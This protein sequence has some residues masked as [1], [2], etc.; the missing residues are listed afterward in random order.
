M[1]RRKRTPAVRPAEQTSRAAVDQRTVEFDEYAP[2]Y[3]DLLRHPVRDLFAND[4]GYF[5][6]RKWILIHDFFSKRGANTAD[7]TWLDVGCGQGELLALGAK[8]FNRAVGCDPSKKMITTCTE[9]DV[10]EQSSPSELPFP[11]ESFDF[12]T[13]VCVYHHVELKDRSS[14]TN[15]IHRVLKRGGIFCLIEH[16]PY[17]PVTQLIV[18]KC[19]VDARARLLTASAAARLL[20]SAGL[21]IIETAYFLYF[22]EF[23]FGHTGWIENFLRKLPVG[24]QFV[25]F[26]RKAAA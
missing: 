14:L 15:S 23:I 26:G 6:R 18:K 16:N 3:S 12:V 25:I 11:G 2:A 7:L 13:A 22:P 24:G 1:I 21:G 10:F 5:H 19:P 9:A 17:N 8:R 20:R 4:P